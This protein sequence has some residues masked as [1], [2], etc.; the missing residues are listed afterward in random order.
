MGVMKLK[1][2]RLLRKIHFKWEFKKELGRTNITKFCRQFLHKEIGRINQELRGK[3]FSVKF[4][5]EI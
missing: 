1:T 4:I 3:G 5:W 2:R